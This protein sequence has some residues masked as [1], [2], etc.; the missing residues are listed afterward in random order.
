LR[1]DEAPSDRFRAP[2]HRLIASR[3]PTVGVFDSVASADDLE[4]ALLLE[5]LTN[6]HSL[7]SEQ[8]AGLEPTLP[9]EEGGEFGRS[10]LI[11]EFAL[12]SSNNP[13]WLSTP[14]G[15]TRRRD[16]GGARQSRLVALA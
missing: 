5:S 6:D 10:A 2:T 12:R 15:R 8:S 13:P 1:P 11:R 3:W 9:L 16:R 4:A 7:T 14:L